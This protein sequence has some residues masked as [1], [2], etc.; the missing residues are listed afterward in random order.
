MPGEW[1]SEV[2][3][4]L[5]RRYRGRP[6]VV[7]IE[8]SGGAGWDLIPRVA[9]VVKRGG[10][11]VYPTDTLYGLGA[12]PF[13]REAVL[14]VYRA[15]GRPLD[16]P[17][18]VLVSSLE[19]AERLV[20]FTPEA[21][22]L[23]ERFWPGALTLV[24]PLRGD[25]GVP[26][27]LHAGTGRLAVRMPGHPVALRL[28]EEAG[29]ALTGTSANRH[30]EPPPRTAL[31]ALQQLGQAVDIVIDSGPA[32]RGEPSTIVDLSGGEPLLIRRGAVA[33]EEIESVL[34]KKL[35]KPGDSEAPAG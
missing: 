22:R 3:E 27:E 17:L 6:L 11:V 20:V 30:R 14:R 4:E 19:A 9:E 34:G 10:L 16:R 15:K 32:P 1:S 23:A 31:E 35:R 7:R 18:P 12:D 26:R 24:L 25:A 2:L 33:P 5:F 28:I 21:R 29:G 8:P 13:N